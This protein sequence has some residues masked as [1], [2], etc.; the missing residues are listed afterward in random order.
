MAHSLRWAGQEAQFR[1]GAVDHHC[2]VPTVDVVALE[3]GT[4]AAVDEPVFLMGP[5]GE[6]VGL[7]WLEILPMKNSWDF[8]HGKTPVAELWVF[9]LETAGVVPVVRMAVHPV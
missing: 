6:A 7:R 8:P 3:Q 4:L 5:G 1:V 9:R 2:S